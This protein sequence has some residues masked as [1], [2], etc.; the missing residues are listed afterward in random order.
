MF[1]ANTKLGIESLKSESHSGI[2]EKP[3]ME[4]LLD[5]Q[6]TPHY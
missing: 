2:A 3:D 4:R 6:P 5:L 1:I